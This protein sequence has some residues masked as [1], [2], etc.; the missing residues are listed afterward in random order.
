MFKNAKQFKFFLNLW[1][2]LFFCGIKILEVSEDYRY[3]KV[4]LR[5]NRWTTNG[6]GVH[7]GGSLFSMT[8]P[9]YVLML[10]STLGKKYIVWDKAADIEFVAPGKGD[11]YAE[12]IITEEM[13]SDI[14][15]KTQHGAKYLPS[16]T[17][18]VKD[19]SGQ[20]VAKVSRTLYIRHK[21]INR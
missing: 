3:A 13:I 14:K 7:Y 4:K 18:H 11:V 1:P 2:P 5:H 6:F 10:I 20:L 15:D 9:F 19:E 17:V 8:D 16:F 21:K 12:F